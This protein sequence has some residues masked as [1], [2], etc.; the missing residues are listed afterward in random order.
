MFKGLCAFPLT[1]LTEGEIEEKSFISLI[2]NLVAAGVDAIGALGST[3][4]YAYLTREQ[5]YQATKLA[6]STA[7]NIPVI[8]SIGHVRFEE[9]VRL[10]ED[11]QKAGVS[12]VLLA[13]L[14]YQPLST[15]EVFRFYER[16]S[17]ELSVPLCIYDNPATTK[18][19]FTD[20]L[21]I[22]LSALNQVGS[23]KLS[24]IPDNREL[25][26]QRIDNLKTRV[27]K[28][29]TIG[30][31]GDAQSANGLM[32]G[33]DVWYSV[34]GG[35]FPHYSLALTQAALSQDERKTHKLNSDLNPL[36]AFY[37]RHG[38]LRVIA[39][40]AEIMGVVASPCLP[41]PLQTLTGEER[42]SLVQTLKQL[43]FLL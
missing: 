24:E 42:A 13:P 31:S 11:A 5:R 37:H 9:V 14:S 32:W 20:E 40:V 22:A 23:I 43:D 29:V 18:F 10:A 19:E 38:S 33:C 1:P 28:G 3:G 17:A 8:T 36:W 41:F 6:V 12:G 4:S 2:E 21:L 27:A 7:A 25:A 39:T 35:M 26:L 30:I 34:I 16:I 15:D